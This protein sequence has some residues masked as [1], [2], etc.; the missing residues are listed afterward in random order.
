MP[1]KAAMRL[2]T[3]PLPTAFLAA[4]APDVGLFS[5]FM[6]MPLC[7]WQGERG[8]YQ[9]QETASLNNGS[10]SWGKGGDCSD[11][12]LANCASNSPISE[13]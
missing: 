7:L 4:P 3:P 5:G 11:L 8:L 2:P 12:G 9:Q 10:S 6:H 13:F 1:G